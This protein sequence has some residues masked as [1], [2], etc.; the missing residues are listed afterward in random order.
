[1]PAVTNEMPSATGRVFHQRRWRFSASQIGM[2][3][4]W[5]D[6]FS[7]LVHKKIVVAHSSTFWTFAWKTEAPPF[8]RFET[9]GGE[10]AIHLGAPHTLT[11]MFTFQALDH[12]ETVKLALR[13]LELVELSD[14]HL[15][16][17]IEG[18]ARERQ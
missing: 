9:A 13:A 11:T 16:P 15:R 4:N 14:R 17:R 1:M 3:A 6:A 5:F 7:E 8:E 18:K 12:Y 10:L 2:L